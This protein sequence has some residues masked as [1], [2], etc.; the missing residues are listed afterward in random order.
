MVRPF[1]DMDLL[2]MDLFDVAVIGYTLE[3]PYSYP[4]LDAYLLYLME[5]FHI[6]FNFY[7]PRLDHQ[8]SV[9]IYRHLF[10]CYPLKN[11]WFALSSSSLLNL[12]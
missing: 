3:V 11:N 9:Y 5:L 12:F 10:S 6:A 4:F 2:I 7:D 1:K 8:Y